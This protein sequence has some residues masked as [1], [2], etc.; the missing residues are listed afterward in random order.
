MSR[1][2]RIA[3]LAT[4]LLVSVGLGVAG[5][6][7][8]AGTAQAQPAP[9]TPTVIPEAAS[10]TIVDFLSERFD[11]RPT[12]VTCPSGVESKVGQAFECQFTGPE[13]PYTAYMQITKVYGQSVEFN[14]VTRRN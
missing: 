4:T 7:L 5:L 12:D 9:A 3:G 2:S 11:F 6:G 14:I 13:G 8:V 1:A 10:Q